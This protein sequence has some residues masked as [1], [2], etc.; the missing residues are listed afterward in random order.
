M[1]TNF[2]KYF[3]LKNYLT[4]L[5]YLIP[6]LRGRCKETY[7]Q[8]GEDLLIRSALKM[9]GVE[10]P[11]YLDIGTNYPILGNNTF[12][13]YSKGS[14]GVC[15]EPNPDL[16]KL[17][18]GSRKRD[19]CLNIGV[20]VTNN[21]SL[22]FY[23]MSANALSTFVKS[24]AD[25]YV[26]ENN[27]GTQ[28]IEKIIKVPVTSIDSIMTRYFPG[29]V[30]VVSLDTEG[31]DFEILKSLNL[32]EYR[33]KVFCVE[34]LRYEKEK[35]LKKQDEIIAFMAERGYFLYA[36]TYINSIFVDKGIWP[37]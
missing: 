35:K 19:I 21:S 4:Y 30:D 32:K 7:S 23:V 1:I 2:K 22:N 14:C 15:I 36:D 25:K 37:F 26:K 31:Y 17:I 24:E 5:T 28:R 27:Y 10:K 29:G 34:T 18:V 11:S 16:F 20:G 8:H 12:L 3:V 9:I 13:F 6:C 33:P